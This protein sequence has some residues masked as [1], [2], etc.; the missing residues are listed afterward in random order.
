[1]KTRVLSVLFSAV[2]AISVASTAYASNKPSPKSGKGYVVHS[3][4]DGHKATIAYN[5]RG[6]WVYTI[7]YY[8]LGNID[9]NIM[10]R[11]RP[12]YYDYNVT[13]MEKDPEWALYM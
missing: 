13:G 4:I 12:V 5:K 6:K 9:K 1:M 10:D 3:I 11:I 8:N 2:V 7:Q